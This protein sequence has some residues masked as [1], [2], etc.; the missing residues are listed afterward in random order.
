MIT[1]FTYS[2]SAVERGLWEY[3]NTLLG[4][5]EGVSAYG[6]RLLPSTVG[7]VH[8]IMWRFAISGGDI[9]VRRQTRTRLQG[10]L[11]VMSAEFE[12][13][14]VDD[15]MIMEVGGLIMGGTPVEKT[16]GIDGLIRCDVTKYPTRSLDSVRIDNSDNAGQEV[17][18]L[19]L[20][21]PMEVVFVNTTRRT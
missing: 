4:T 11:W 13:W 9:D 21:I 18:G 2:W 17:Q 15:A 1:D 20:S 3:F 14:S 5:I 6:Y 7:G 12:A 8:D 19:K 10:G 16:D